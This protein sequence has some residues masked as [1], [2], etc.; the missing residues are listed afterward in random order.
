MVLLNVTILLT[1]CTGQDNH[2]RGRTQRS[3][4]TVT[5]SKPVTTITPIMPATSIKTKTVI[6]MH[7][8]SMSI[9]SPRRMQRR[10]VVTTQRAT[11]KATQKDSHRKFG[12]E[13]ARRVLTP[14]VPTTSGACTAAGTNIAS[15]AISLDTTSRHASRRTATRI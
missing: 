3:T 9:T 5:S 15:I 2:S 6:G 12:Q 4:L 13:N 10:A 8:S 11:R 1:S 7:H 14:S